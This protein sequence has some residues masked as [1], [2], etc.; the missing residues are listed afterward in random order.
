LS[1]LWS[2]KP[3]RKTGQDAGA[4]RTVRAGPVRMRGPGSA[5]ATL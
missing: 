3:V 5:D 4:A 2:T 1:S